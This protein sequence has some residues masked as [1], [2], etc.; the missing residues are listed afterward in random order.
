MKN[1]LLKIILVFC[2]GIASMYA[3]GQVGG[4]TGTVTD[5]AGEL[6]IGAT[7][8]MQG[9]T[10]GTITSVEGT[11][12]ISSLPTAPEAISLLPTAFAAISDEPTA[13]VAISLLPTAFAAMPGFG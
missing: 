13:S 9:T 12:S 8:L 6:L 2:L 5:N 3:R 11:Y 7:V 10:V 1:K 4:A